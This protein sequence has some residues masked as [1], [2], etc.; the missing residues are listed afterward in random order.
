MTE[1][2][3]EKKETTEEKTPTEQ[4]NEEIK[5]QEEK[6]R[7]DA[8][9][10]IIDQIKNTKK[11]S[12]EQAKKT[13]EEL[14]K[15]KKEREKPKE[16]YKPSSTD[17]KIKALLDFDHI[18]E[19]FY[20]LSILKD[21]E[22][23]LFLEHYKNKEIP[24]TKDNKIDLI[25]RNSDNHHEL[26]DNVRDEI[27]TSVDEEIQDI[28]SR[29]ST[30]AKKGKDTYVEM[31]KLL[32]APLKLKIFKATGN[33]DDFYKA[34]KIISG[35]E[36]TI[37]P[38]EEELEREL[39]Q[40]EQEEKEREEK[41]KR[42]KEEKA[43]IKAGEPTK[44]EEKEETKRPESNK[45]EEE[46]PEPE[47]KGNKEKQNDPVDLKTPNAKPKHEEEKPKATEISKEKA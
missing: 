44:K 6:E 39:K 7:Q 34:K 18:E 30:L 15:I 47:K 42:A 3:E 22:V 1:S 37:K 19:L 43:K 36:E 2:K 11:I 9:K 14:E 8:R 32:Q 33:K 4:S 40:R 41:E 10:P 35:V 17:E 46:S 29:M 28:K 20:T 24:P 12:D 23:K 26:R 21:K 31:M 5:K 16:T 13:S 45:K 25:I 27:A 38:K